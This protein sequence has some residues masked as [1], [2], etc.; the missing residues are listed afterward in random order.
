MQ[1]IQ[2]T[3]FDLRVQLGKTAK[4]LAMTSKQQWVPLVVAF[5]E[6]NR[7]CC[8]TEYLDDPICHC[9]VDAE[10]LPPVSFDYADNDGTIEDQL[11]LLLS[12]HT[13]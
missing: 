7:Q 1:C 4:S 6:R 8:F 9:F 5:L 13:Q 2:H 12:D 3:W 10:R 11:M